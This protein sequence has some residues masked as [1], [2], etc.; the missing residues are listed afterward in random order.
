[1]D[2][3]KGMLKAYEAWVAKNPDV[4]GDFETTAK[5]VSYFIAGRISSPNVLRELV[6]TLSKLLV[7]YNDRIIKRARNA[8]ENSVIQLQSK[9]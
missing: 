9:L 4:V 8:R 7:F 6:Y 2:T 1:M 5:W 3:L